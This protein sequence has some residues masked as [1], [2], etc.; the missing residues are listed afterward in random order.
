MLEALITN[1]EFEK[2][3]ASNAVTQL[4]QEL[5]KN[6]QNE[7]VRQHIENMLLYLTNEPEGQVSGNN[8]Y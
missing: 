4:L 6:L 3:I 5:N 2:A 8:K 1:E 7:I